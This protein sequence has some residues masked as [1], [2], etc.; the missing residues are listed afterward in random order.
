MSTPNY[1]F[2]L[3][4]VGEHKIG[5]QGQVPREIAREIMRN[6][7]QEL[8]K[9]RRERRLDKIPPPDTREMNKPMSL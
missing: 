1:G 4:I 6:T 7:Q 9:L 8:E 2:E 5:K 3:P